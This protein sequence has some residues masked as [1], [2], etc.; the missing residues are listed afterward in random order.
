MSRA[1][2]RPA[3]PAIST[4]TPSSFRTG[5][6]PAFQIQRRDRDRRR[7]RSPPRHS[8]TR[9]PRTTRAER[10]QSRRAEAP[11]RTAEATETAGISRGLKGRWPLRATQIG[12]SS[13]SLFMYYLTF[14]DRCR[15]LRPRGGVLDAPTNASATRRSSDLAAARS[16][17]PTGNHAR[18]R[19]HDGAMA[20]DAAP[21][22]VVVL[23][24][25]PVRTSITR[26]VSPTDDS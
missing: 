11:I 10:P 2:A 23:T 6:W 19:L 18:I 3:A 8:Q 21:I 5:D 14:G 4:N 24:I 9:R 1:S 20:L 22:D 12:P 13:P 26:M 15:G 25:S 17:P 16:R 7:C